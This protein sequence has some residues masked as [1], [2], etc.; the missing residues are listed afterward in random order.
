MLHSP[1]SLLHFLTQLRGY[2]LYTSFLLVLDFAILLKSCLYGL[3]WQNNGYHDLS[4][5][6][7]YLIPIV[8]SNCANLAK[9]T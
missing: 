1:L 7:L 9:V 4:F 6:M 8:I 3:R 5:S 2:L